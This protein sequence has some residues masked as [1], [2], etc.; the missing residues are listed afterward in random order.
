MNIQ[1]ISTLPENMELFARENNK[2][3][4]PLMNHLRIQPF[5]DLVMINEMNMYLCTLLLAI[6]VYRIRSE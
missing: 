1:G 5:Y 2:D 4:H 6:L 3:T